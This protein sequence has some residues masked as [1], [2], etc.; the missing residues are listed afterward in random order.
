[1][2]EYFAENLEAHRVDDEIHPGETTEEKISLSERFGL[3]ISFYPFSQDDYLDITWH[4]ARQLGVS[5]EVIA[6]S[7]REALNWALGRGS[8][9]GRVAW[10][11]ARDLAGRQNPAGEEKP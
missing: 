1:M 5:E 7:E 11:F 6:V 8:R 9:S 3:W 4:W 10:Q 2:P